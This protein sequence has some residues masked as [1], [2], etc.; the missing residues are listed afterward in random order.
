[1]PDEAVVCDADRSLDR[2]GGQLVN[3]IKNLVFIM[4]FILLAGVFATCAVCGKAAHDVSEGK[5][6]DK[7][8]KDI[9]DQVATDSVEQYRIAKRNGDAVDACV[10]AGLVAAAYLQA[11]DEASYQK[12]KDIERSDCDY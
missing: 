3:T 7:V 6:G 5:A 2:G 9:H 10:H 8:M 4:L 12:W 11:K 1:M